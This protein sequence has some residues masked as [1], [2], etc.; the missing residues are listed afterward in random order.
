MRGQEGGGRQSLR[1]RRGEGSRPD[2]Y[3]AS[4]ARA[5]LHPFRAVGNTGGFPSGAPCLL[6]GRSESTVSRFSCFLV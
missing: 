2:V 1:G 3:T 4:W 5:L 6:K